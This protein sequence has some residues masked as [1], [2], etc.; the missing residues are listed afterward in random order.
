MSPRSRRT[1]VIVILLLLAVIILLL[2]RCSRP[3]PEPA[4]KSTVP[5]PRKTAVGES[6]PLAPKSEEILTTATVQA[7]VQIEAGA[8]FRASWTGPNNA[9]DYLTIVRSSA[10]PEFYGNYRETRYGPELDL[11][12][13]MEAGEWEV[14]YVAAK[15]K[16][17]LGRATVTVTATSATLSAPDEVVLGS[18]VAITW[19]GPNHKGD[20]VCIVRKDAA[21]DQV[22]NY[23]D[24]SRGSPLTIPAPVEGGE[25]EIRYVSGQ[26]RKVLG[27]RRLVVTEPETSVTAQA[28]VIAGAKF[29][30]TWKGP[31]NAGDYVT[32]VPRGAPD[33]QYRSYAEVAKGAT[34]EL[35]APIEAGEAE[36]RYMTGKQA[37]VLARRPITIVTASVSLDAP[38]EVI[39]GAA[40]TIAWTGP[41]NT[42]DY[43]TVVPKTMPDGQYGNYTNAAKG[44]PLKVTA[45]IHAGPA[46]IRYMSG[47]GAKVLA[48][49]AIAIVAADISLRAPAEATS[50]A[51]VDVEW[52]GPNNPG[53]Y[54]T[55]VPKSTKDGIAVRMVY[56]AR[57]SPAKI[58]A[59]KDA[60]VCE[61]RY[62][63]G[64]HNVVLARTEIVVR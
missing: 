8:A 17:V 57:G 55:I 16:T 27:R 60:G 26:G 49:R 50:G 64:Q 6:A 1:L 18:P 63:S 41:N 46:E 25:A 9:G 7:P 19:V 53:D 34:L 58:P 21:D 5:E 24:A 4:P 12:A 36:L 35:A 11:T 52:K 23:V 29:S 44:T 32:I 37:R 20:F 42:G 47:S 61:V 38:D 22:G 39:A 51:T 3:A 14:R 45:P 40:V 54:F 43:I 33:G 10:R 15:S 13:P 62:M 48:R 56:T 28:S 2:T 30:V 59:P 31:A